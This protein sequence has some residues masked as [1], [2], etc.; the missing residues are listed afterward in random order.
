MRFTGTVLPGGRLHG[1]THGDHASVGIITEAPGPLL[2]AGSGLPWVY[3]HAPRRA[4]WGHVHTPRLTPSSTG[5]REAREGSSHGLPHERGGDTSGLS[6]VLPRI[7]PGRLP[8]PPG[9]PCGLNPQD[10]HPVRAMALP[11]RSHGPNPTAGLAPWV[12]ISIH[13]DIENVEA[14]KQ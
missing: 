14:M 8:R 13:Q 2:P 5:P 3:S 4:T 12:K 1:K 6:W 10:R 7:Q 11:S 9:L